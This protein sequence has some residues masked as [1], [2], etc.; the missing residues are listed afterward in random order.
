MASR[1]NHQIRH[2]PVVDHADDA[3]RLNSGVVVHTTY[4]LK[5]VYETWKPKMSLSQRMKARQDVRQLVAGRLGN[6]SAV[7][8]ILC[9]LPHLVI[10]Q[11]QAT[12]FGYNPTH[13]F[14]LLPT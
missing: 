3:E 8:I 10:Q 4:E 13:S 5:V 9:T 14:T 7:Y 6:R 1:I 11:A 12:Y 2:A